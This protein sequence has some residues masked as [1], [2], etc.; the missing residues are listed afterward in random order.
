MNLRAIYILYCLSLYIVF[1]SDPKAELNIKD[2]NN[3]IIETEK[4]N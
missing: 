1:I 4:V 2:M 3:E